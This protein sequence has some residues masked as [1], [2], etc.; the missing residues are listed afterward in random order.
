MLGIG[1][2]TSRVIAAAAF[3]L[4]PRVL[5]TVGSISSETLPI[6]LAPWVLLPTIVALRAEPGRSVRRL[7]GQAGLAV[8]LMGAVNA[9]ATVAG[10]LPAVVWWACH[11]PC[12]VWWRYTGWWLL[13]LALATLWWLVALILLARISPPFLDFIES[14]GVTTQWSS[15][16]EVLRGT[17]SWTPFVAPTQPRARRW[18]PARWPSWAPAWSRPAAWRPGWVSRARRAG[19]GRLVTMLLVGIVLLAAGYSGGL[20]SPLAHQVQAFLDAG[21]APLRNVHK[22]ESLIRI[23]VALGLAQLLGRIPLPAAPGPRL[24]PRIRPSRTRQAGCGRN[25][26]ADRTD[27]QYLAGLDWPAHAA[28]HLPCDTS[29]LARRR[30]VARRAQHGHADARTGASG[31]WRTLRHPGLGTSHDEPLQVLGDSR[32]GYV[33]PSR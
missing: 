28:G 19:S 26:G 14:S 4:S 32:G 3:A 5:T 6:M 12:R 20:G 11:R 2:P 22:L 8:A 15:L 16:V 24:G 27:G 10:C 21:G 25:R 18:S 30:R 33:T 29:I 13:A 17:A 1:S 31:S 9:I 23:P 7:A